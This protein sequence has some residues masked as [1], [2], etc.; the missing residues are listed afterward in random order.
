M[1]EKEKIIKKLI[2]EIKDRLDILESMT[3][4]VSC[5]NNIDERFKILNTKI[6]DVDLST[7]AKNGLKTI[8]VNNVKD[9]LECSVLDIAY[10]RNI[11]KLTSYEIKTFIFDLCGFRMNYD[12]GIDTEKFLKTGEILFLEKGRK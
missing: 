10:I 12:K 1:E 8:G 6:E 9:L 7:R 2:K 4:P 5:K 3:S 11:G